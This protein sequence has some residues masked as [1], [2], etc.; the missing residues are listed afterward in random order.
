VAASIP[1]IFG[2]CIE[3]LLIV[4]QTHFMILFIS[5]IELWEF[6]MYPDPD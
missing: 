3:L 6:S 4:S 2:M 1:H 5:T